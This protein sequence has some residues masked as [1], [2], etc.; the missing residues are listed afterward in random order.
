MIF[1]TDL[2]STRFGN[3]K[4]SFDAPFLKKISSLFMKNMLKQQFDDRI[5]F[6][7]V[8]KDILI[9]INDFFL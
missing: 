3:R 2:G 4:N 8:L 6:R 5:L 1:C 7:F 9:N